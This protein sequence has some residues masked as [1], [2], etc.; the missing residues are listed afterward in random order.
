MKRRKFLK[1]I[2]VVPA[3]GAL[4]SCDPVAEKPTPAGSQAAGSR[5]VLIS[6]RV[7]T[8]SVGRFSIASSSRTMFS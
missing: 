8:S 5:A 2:A 7:V 4:L 1:T 3:S 6:D